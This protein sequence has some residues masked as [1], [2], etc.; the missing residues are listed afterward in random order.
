MQRPNPAPSRGLGATG[1][2]APLNARDKPH[3]WEPW[4]PRKSVRELADLA[5]VKLGNVYHGRYH[6]VRAEE[7]RHPRMGRS[8]PRGVR[9]SRFSHE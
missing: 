8:L 5:Q 7:E 6:Q 3:E 2:L 1:P 4:N 9:R